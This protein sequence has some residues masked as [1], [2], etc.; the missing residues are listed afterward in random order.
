MLAVFSSQKERGMP[1]PE[2]SV[3]SKLVILHVNNGIIL[4]ICHLVLAEAEA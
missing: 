1:H 4:K 2:C 3:Q